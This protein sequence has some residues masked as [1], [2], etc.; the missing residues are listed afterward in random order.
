MMPAFA[1]LSRIESRKT[2]RAADIK[3]DNE[4]THT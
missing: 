3:E 2:S 1:E 4:Q